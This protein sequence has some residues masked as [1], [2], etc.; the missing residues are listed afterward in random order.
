[1]VYFII[2]LK[3]ASSISESSKMY[4]YT[5]L[6]YI[7]HDIP[8]IRNI[9]MQLCRILPRYDAF[10][11]GRTAVGELRRRRRHYSVRFR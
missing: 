3:T 6:N 4:E 1:M 7:V 11:G 5:P 2:G 8:Y 9:S 10:V